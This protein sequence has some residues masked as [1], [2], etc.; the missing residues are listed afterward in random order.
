M[1]ST[2]AVQ[3]LLVSTLSVAALCFASAYAQAPA[4]QKPC[5]SIPACAEQLT[6][7][8]QLTKDQRDEE[9]LKAFLVLYAQFPDPRLCVGIG[10]MLHRRGQY[11]KAAIFYQRLLDSGVETD[12]QKLN[13]VR[14]F[15][16]EARAGMQT[17]AH[18]AAPG[19]PQ[20]TLSA[21]LS[22]ATSAP[23]KPTAVSA[24]AVPVSQDS[25]ARTQRAV[26][27]PPELRPIPITPGPSP[28]ESASGLPTASPRALGLRPIPNA[29]IA[30]GHQAEAP[31][32]Q[33]TI[34]AIAPVES[35]PS[36]AL[37]DLKPFESGSGVST[38]TQDRT[39]IYKRWW[40][41]TAIGTVTAGVVVGAAL[42]AY[43]REPDWP[44]VETIHPYP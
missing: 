20:P 3:L 37:S 25:V 1:T 34:P 11:E 29:T 36:P 31:L 17:E 18:A 38:R 22:S 42:G 7:A 28:S 6:K 40:F 14:R 5:A 10:R 8:N 9:A 44:G 16:V 33:S 26:P 43:A 15:L 19:H 39:P 35:A 2:K 12:P 4:L 21:G 24:S 30:T 27:P 23:S 13:K 41:W 32:N